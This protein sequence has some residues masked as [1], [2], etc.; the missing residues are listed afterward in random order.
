MPG[1]ESRAG[2][3]LPGVAVIVAVVV[4]AAAWFWW[5]DRQLDRDAELVCAAWMASDGRHAGDIAQD[6]VGGEFR[7]FSFAAERCPGPFRLARDRHAVK[8][9]PLAELQQK[10]S[11]PPPTGATDSRCEPSYPGICIFTGEPDIDCEDVGASAFRVVGS[12]PHRFD[13][14]RDGLGCE[15]FLNSFEDDA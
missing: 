7:D 4:A 11:A 5:N 6:A 14:D 12:D 3:W 8:D 9:Q 13:R 1:N 15:P 10:L 2:G